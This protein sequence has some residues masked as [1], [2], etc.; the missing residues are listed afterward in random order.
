[1]NYNNDIKEIMRMAF[2]HYIDDIRRFWNVFYVMSI[3]NGGLI[4]IVISINQETPLRIGAGL[5]GLLVCIIWCGAQKRLR[6]WCKNWEEKLE[7]LEKT[8]LSNIKQSRKQSIK[9]FVGRKDKTSKKNSLP[10]ISGY[11]VGILLPVIFACAW[12]F[13][14]GYLFVF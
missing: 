11:C 9:V 12:I 10:G 7:E 4:A 1:M 8:F 13:I 3:L 14:I 6:F 5:L 2:D